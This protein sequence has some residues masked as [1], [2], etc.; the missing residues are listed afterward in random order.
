MCGIFGIVYASERTL[1][2][3]LTGAAN[4]LAYRGY[5][6]VGAAAIPADGAIDLRKEVGKVREVAEELRFDELFGLRGIV[7]LRW[8]TFGAPSVPNAQPHLDSDGTLVGAHNGNVVNNAE[9]RRQ[10]IAEGMKVRGTNDGESC[11]HAVERHVKRG[12]GL[13][14]AVRA[15][16]N[17]LE[18]DFAFVISDREHNRLVAV[19]K[20]SGLVVGIGPDFTCCSSDL[21]S[22]LPLTRK[23]IPVE[24]GEMVVLEPGRVRL[25]HVADGSKVIRPAKEVSDKMGAAEKGGYDHF[26]LKEIH[27]Q[28][29]TAR[30]LLHLLEASEYLPGMVEKLRGAERLFLVGS[31]SSYHACLIGSTF[32]A[33]LAGKLAVPALPHQ[34]IE[35]YGQALRPGDVAL[36]VSQSGETKDVLNAIGF[37]T[38]KG[39][40]P[41]GLVNV[42]GSTMTRKVQVYLPLACGWE[43]S[44]PATKTYTNQV[45]ALIA[46][47]AAVGGQPVEELDAAPAWIERAIAKTD[48]PMTALAQ[49]FVG[50]DRLFILGYGLG[51]GVAREGALK[52]KEVTGLPCEGMFSSE[53]KHG[54]LA[55]V[56]ED[57]PVFFTAPPS[58]AEMLTNHVTEVTARAGHAT[59]L[60][61]EHKGLRAEA[62]RFIPLPVGSDL[63]Y[64]IVGAVP[65]QLL[66][67]HLAVA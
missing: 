56:E 35:Q 43:I 44:V 57:T 25:F 24:D 18:G 26:M 51:H 39:V 58:G 55:M 28:P 66:G 4:R 1:G 14:E 9:L 16:Y 7:Q 29:A 31:G 5:D 21:P 60:A 23:V 34:L 3:V 30:A 67:Y 50:C 59:V 64:A 11:V 17:D 32:W 20:G 15:A 53:F 48:G 52:C 19:K 54:P 65:F 63:E 8:A 42:L 12:L 41:L 62:S 49:Q 45:I 27:E 33:R 22:I 10:F 38:P 6:S 13:P 40:L 47:A 36:Y 61:A 37:A 2:E 46:L